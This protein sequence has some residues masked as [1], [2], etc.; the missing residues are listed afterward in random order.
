M[1]VNGIIKRKRYLILTMQNTENLNIT[2][3]RNE[4]GILVQYLFTES[5]YDGID[6]EVVGN[7]DFLSFIFCTVVKNT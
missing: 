6:D 7:L 1:L 2:M 3:R 5:I 4:N